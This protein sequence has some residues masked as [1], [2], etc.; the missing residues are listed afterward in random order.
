MEDE[1]AWVVFGAMGT[2]TLGKRRREKVEYR[3][4]Q[5]GPRPVIQGKRRRR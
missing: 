4:G 2:K 3:A 1:G 5:L